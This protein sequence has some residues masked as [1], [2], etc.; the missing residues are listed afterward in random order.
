M[1]VYLSIN[2]EILRPRMDQNG[3]GY[4]KYL[5]YFYLEK[6]AQK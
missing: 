4:Y 3:N 1:V 6:Y 2:E 5:G